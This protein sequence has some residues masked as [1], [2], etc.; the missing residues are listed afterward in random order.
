MPPPKPLNRDQEQK[1]L[2]RGLMP[3]GHNKIQ[4]TRVIKAVLKVLSRLQGIKAIRVVHNR[5]RDLSLSNLH[6]FASQK[7]TAQQ[8]CLFV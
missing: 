8:R 5:D 4:D 2:S 1:P 6:F 3:E 7:G